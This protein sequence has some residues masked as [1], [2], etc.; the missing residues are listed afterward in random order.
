MK[1]KMV[2]IIIS[3]IISVIG[4][5]YCLSYYSP[6]SYAKLVINQDHIW[7]AL[8]GFGAMGTLLIAYRALETWELEK[9][10]DVT[11]DNLALCNVAVEFISFLRQ[12]TNHNNEIKAEY[13][14]ILDSSELTDPQARYAERA[15]YLYYS[16]KEAKKD[17]YDAILKLR[18]INWAVYGTDHDF[19]KF[20]NRIVEIDEEIRIATLRRFFVK[21]DR[22]EYDLESYKEIMSTTR[23]I[24]V[25]VGGD[26]R[27][28]KDLY[29]MVLKMQSHRKRK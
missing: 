28:T 23:C 24:I 18:E 22:E 14:A 20:Y 11:I 26:D 27:I 17:I 3:I 29:D 19:Y 7:Y 6:S 5:I 10:Y 16:R 8:A 13:Q 21:K 25:S 15:V 4:L 1:Y 12:P 2:I 9:K